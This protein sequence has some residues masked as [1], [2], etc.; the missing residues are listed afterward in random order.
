MR[1][2]QMLRP[3]AGKAHDALLGRLQARRPQMEDALLTRARA[4]S[5]SAAHD[6][7]CP[8][9]LRSAVRTAL[10]YAFA[11]FGEELTAP[12]P[13]LLAQTRIAAR[14]GVGLDVIQ[15]CY[16]TGHA[17]LVDF[18]VEEAGLLGLGSGALQTLLRTLASC[19]D[20]L[21]VAVGEEHAREL[22]DCQSSA[23]QRDAERID[24]LLA[25]ELVSVSHFTYD[26]EGSH[27]GA[28]AKGPG[29]AEAVRS[30][31]ASLDRRLLLITRQ[32]GLVW[33]W[34]GGREPI[35]SHEL[36]GD[37]ICP[38]GT[39]VALGESA[40]GLSGWRLTHR[41]AKAAMTVAFR[42]QKP[43]IRYAEVALL[44]SI[45]HDDLLS[46]SLRQ[47]Y[48]EPLE[49]ERDGGEAA[50]ET[51]HAYF[52]TERNV[53]SA[54]VVLGVSRRTVAN[55]LRSVEEHLERPLSTCAAEMEAALRLH[56]FEPRPQSV[57]DGAN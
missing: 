29:A 27:L 15:R 9:G 19:L 46:T 38:A 54:A 48:L 43:S 35:D 55:R 39:T 11:A 53:S 57:G 26:F 22:A 20:R 50:R 24:R 2:V 30:L 13:M 32:E 6:P 25:G 33:A 44:A 28:V 7:E 49:R 12:P 31:A 17:L 14:N 4:V 5:S 40:H 16:I 41:Q 51:L 8:D 47:L 37:A 23:E 18:F 10:D 21:L 36:Q 56:A 52:A 3:S 34:L 42:V 1:T 45:F